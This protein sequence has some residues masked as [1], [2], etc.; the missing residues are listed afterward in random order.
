MYLDEIMRYKPAK[1]VTQNI[2]ESDRQIQKY[3]N[4]NNNNSIIIILV[5]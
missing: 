1:K 5:A 3:D 2:V 4:N